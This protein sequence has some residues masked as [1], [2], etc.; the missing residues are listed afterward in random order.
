MASSARI[1]SICS[2]MWSVA[3]HQRS[4]SRK[5]SFARSARNTRVHFV[6]DVVG[7]ELLLARRLLHLVVAGVGVALQVADVG[8]VDD[9][10]HA[11]AEEAQ[12]A[13]QEIREQVGA[14]VAQ[15]LAAVDRG[16]QE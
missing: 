13:V 9:V 16:P 11:E 7:R 15:V 14:Q 10:A 2:G 6:G 4:G 8:D 3:L 12:R 1:I 5:W